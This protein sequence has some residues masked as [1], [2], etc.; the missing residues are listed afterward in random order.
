LIAKWPSHPGNLE[1]SSFLFA[2]NM[3]AIINEDSAVPKRWRLTYSPLRHAEYGLLSQLLCSTAAVVFE[4]LHYD[5][6][7]Y[8]RATVQLSCH[9]SASD[10]SVDISD[11]HATIKDPVLVYAQLAALHT[12]SPVS[13]SVLQWIEFGY[14]VVAPDLA[15]ASAATFGK[16]LALLNDLLAPHQWLQPSGEGGPGPADW[17]LYALL[18]P[19]MR[20]LAP[21]HGRAYPRVVRWWNG[22]NLQVNRLLSSNTSP[23]DVPSSEGVES[24]GAKLASSHLDSAKEGPKHGKRETTGVVPVPSPPEGTDPFYRVVVRVGRIVQVEK[25]PQADRL[26]IEKV[27]VGLD[28]PMTVVSGLVDLV[29]A[30]QLLN[31]LCLFV[32]NLKPASLCKVQSEG[33]LLVSKQDDLLQPLVVPPE[34]RPGMRLLL[35]GDQ[36]EQVY[37][38]DKQLSP[39]ENVWGATVQPRLKCLDGRLVYYPGS[40]ESAIDCRIGGLLPVTSDLVPNGTIS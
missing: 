11:G 16:S 19:R 30:E 22:V 28:A 39:K 23:V 18:Q 36:E 8:K 25:H 31:R 15:S 3:A 2:Y 33:M 17:L 9:H 10:G 7:H 21:T 26:F 20:S 35:D 6:V 12:Q 29:P 24:V 34:A 32:C 14:C 4:E 37:G 5:P 40:D 38:G 27:D 13:P 1:R